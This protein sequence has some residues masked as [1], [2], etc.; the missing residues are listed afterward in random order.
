MTDIVTLTVNGLDYQGWKSVRIEAGL[1]RIA[2]SFELSVTERWPGSVAQIRRITPGDLCEIRIGVDL[3]C[4]GYVDAT[5]IDYDAQGVTIFIKGRSKTADLVDSSADNQSGQFKGLSAEVIAQRLAGQY[6]LT[7]INQTATGSIIT[8]HQIQQGETAFESLDRIA[9]QRQILITDD[10][11]GNVVLASPGGGG[12]ASSALELGVNILSGNAG[13]DYSEVYSQYNVK[14]QRSVSADEDLNWSG[15]IATHKQISQA[16]GTAIDSNIKRRRIL[17][18]RQEGQADSNTCAQRAAYEQQIRRAK[19]GEVRYRVA[20]WRQ[21]D[22]ALWQINK[23]V[24]INDAIM[25]FYGALLISQCI[26]TLDDQGMITEITALPAGAFA[27]KP[28][29]QKKVMARKKGVNSGTDD[30]WID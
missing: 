13:F 6:G 16:F 30:S 15:D 1:E 24:F 20:G 3:M 29:A 4:T 5:P 19:A 22:G 17:I 23:M 27:T 18:V 10:A 14:G 12:N 21:G 8:D 28:E 26:Y 7:V 2:R 9:K 11:S 25:G